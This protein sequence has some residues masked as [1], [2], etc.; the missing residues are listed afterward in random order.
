FVLISYLYLTHYYYLFFFFFFNDT[1][2]TEIYTT[3]DTLSLHDAL[4]ISRSRAAR[5]LPRF[6]S[7]VPGGRS[8]TAARNPL[9]AA[10]ARPHA[11]ADRRQRRRGVLRRQYRSPHRARDGARRRVDHA[12]GPGALCRQ[13]ARPRR[14]QVSRLHD[15]YDAAAVRRGRDP[16][17]DP[18]RDGGVRSG[19]RPRR[20]AAASY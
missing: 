13:V 4:P 19:S 2:T 5:P 17:G 15:L 12:S 14:D 7:A 3:T 16:G 20:T 10:R 18:Q 9:R 6:P 8:R 11:P 1:A